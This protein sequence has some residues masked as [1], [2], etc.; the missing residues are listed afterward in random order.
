MAVLLQDVFGLPISEGSMDNLLERTAQ[1]A[2]P[3]YHTIQQKVQSSEVAGSDETGTSVA[4]KKGWFH[5]WQT[6]TLTFIVASLN[7]GCQT[8]GKYFS[9]GF[10]RSVYVSDCRAAQLKVAA[11]QHQLCTAHLLRELRNF[12]EAPGCTG[13]LP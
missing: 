11:L 7:R 9:V 1:K 8:I 4:G 3:L 5:T 13:G 12:I 10:L 2:L 6:R